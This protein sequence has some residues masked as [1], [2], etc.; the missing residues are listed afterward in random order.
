MQF[1]T[2]SRQLENRFNVLSKIFLSDLQSH[3]NRNLKFAALTV[4]FCAY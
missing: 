1:L 4:N 2:S 3:L